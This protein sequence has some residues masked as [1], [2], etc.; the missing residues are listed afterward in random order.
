MCCA[1]LLFLSVFN[2][3]ILTAIIPQLEELEDVQSREGAELRVRWGWFLKYIVVVELG[4]GVGID[5]PLPTVI[6]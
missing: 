6:I 3:S 2:P 5:I 1:I 4:K